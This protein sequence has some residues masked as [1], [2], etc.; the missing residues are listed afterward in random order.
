MREEETASASSETGLA[1]H[2]CAVGRV[3]KPR[4]VECCEQ[5][6]K[7]SKLSWPDASDQ[8]TWSFSVNAIILLSCQHI[9]S[10]NSHSKWV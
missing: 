7:N 2:G 6:D 3:G 4:E 9:K 1:G 10:T 5:P 8:D